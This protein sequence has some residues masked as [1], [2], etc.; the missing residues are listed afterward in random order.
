MFAYDEDDAD[1]ARLVYIIES[2]ENYFLKYFKIDSAT[3]VVY[4]RKPLHGLAGHVFNATVSVQD[5]PSRSKP[6]KA[7]VNVVVR[8]VESGKRPPEFTF[9]PDE[10]IHLRE[11]ESDRNKAIARFSA[12]SNADDD[13]LQYELPNTAESSRSNT[14][15][16]TQ[17]GRD[18]VVTLA[19]SLDYEL[20]KYYTLTVRVVNKHNLAAVK[21]FSVVVEDVNDEMPYII[22]FLQ[23]A[24]AENEEPGVTVMKVSVSRRPLDSDDKV[25]NCHESNYDTPK[26]RGVILSDFLY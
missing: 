8:V 15:K 18:A 1:N 14:F 22:D 21:Q 26:Y 11:D 5:R 7:Q 6:R 3:G 24:I 2:A 17:N 19:R 13:G 9:Y 23:G 12:V 20:V 16:L 10:P 25:L 4:T